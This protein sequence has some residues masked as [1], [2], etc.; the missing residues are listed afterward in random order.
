[1]KIALDSTP[2]T[3]GPGGIA[4]YT[5]KLRDALRAAY[6]EDEVL[7]FTDQVGVVGTKRLGALRR[8]WWSVGLP[9]AIREA[10]VELFHGTDFA[11]PYVP[12]CATVMTVHDLSP[13]MSEYRAA[14]SA[15]VRRRM[16]WLLRL[17]LATMVVTPTEAVRREVMARFGVPGDRVRATHLGVDMRSTGEP[18]EDF[19]LVV[20]AGARK[21]VEVAEKAAEGLAPLRVVDRDATEEELASFRNAARVLL[22]PSLYEGFGLPAIEAMACG[23]PVI[24]STDPALVEVCGGAA[25]HVDAKD[26]R[27]WREALAAIL[28][29][30]ERTGRMKDEGLKRAAEFTWEK[31]ARATHAVYE[32]ALQRYA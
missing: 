11:V 32:E 13:W 17:K 10:G 5:A 6:P 20:G 27:G 26:V 15:R 8:Q 23:T 21:N 24:A 12:V 25:E 3:A 1:M 14:T 31:C 28:S 9:L 19:V 30:P 2:L 7:E 4:R 18:K 22:M 29:D 16:P